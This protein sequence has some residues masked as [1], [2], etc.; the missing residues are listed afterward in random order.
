M[1][2]TVRTPT[3]GMRTAGSACSPAGQ[4]CTAG[5]PVQPGSRLREP[6][7]TGVRAVHACPE[8][9]QGLHALRTGMHGQHACPAGLTLSRPSSRH[10]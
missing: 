8:G 9:M 3:N 4:A 5:T 1:P 2:H 10:L 6:G 7:W